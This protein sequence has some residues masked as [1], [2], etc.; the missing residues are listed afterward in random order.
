MKAPGAVRHYWRFGGTY[1]L[2]GSLELCR[3]VESPFLAAVLDLMPDLAVLFCPPGVPGDCDEVA[4]LDT[5]PVVED[6]VGEKSP[7]QGHTANSKAQCADRWLRESHTG[8]SSRPQ[9][10]VLGHS[11]WLFADTKIF[12]KRIE[13]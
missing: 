3:L 12:R 1:L 10:S 6:I 5:R 9:E 4:P 11:R 8:N 2:L 7:G 13:K